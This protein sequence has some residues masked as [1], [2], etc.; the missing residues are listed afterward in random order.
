MHWNRTHHADRRG[1]ALADRHYSRKTIGA[2]QF[3]PPGRKVVLLTDA[4]DALWVT[5]WPFTEYVKH[6]W[7]G[8]WL[9]SLFRNEGPVLSSVLI[10]DAV[11][12]TRA[13]WGEPPPLGMVTFIDAGKVRHKRD[14]GRCYLRAGFE[15]CGVTAGGLIVVRLA[16]DAMPDP[17]LPGDMQLRLLDAAD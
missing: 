3:T 6:A 13:I 2:P 14:P 15:R 9:C 1:A 16:P 17:C 4:A 7:A 5:S 12:A 8:A 10:R 11:A